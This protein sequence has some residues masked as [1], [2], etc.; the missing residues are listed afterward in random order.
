MQSEI[1]TFQKIYPGCK[2]ILGTVKISGSS[3]TNLDSLRITKISGGLLINYTENLKNL[4]GLKELNS[5]G[6][7]LSLRSNKTLE[8]IIGLN[9][10]KNIGRSLNIENNT[11][12]K[13]LSG[14]NALESIN[15]SVSVSNNINLTSI[16]GLSNLSSIGEDFAF[17]G[18]PIIK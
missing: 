3:I 11:Q 10:L 4:S 15:G 6:L 16:D 8:S 13:E 1:N 14:L 2:E 5:I 17:I 12:L 9:K 7:E 18:T